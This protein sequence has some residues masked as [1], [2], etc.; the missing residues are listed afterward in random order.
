MGAPTKAQAD[1]AWVVF[2]KGVDWDRVGAD[3]LKWSPSLRKKGKKHQEML[4][5][6]LQDRQFARTFD[7]NQTI[8]KEAY[9]VAWRQKMMMSSDNGL[10]FQV[11]ERVCKEHGLT[12]P[13]LRQLQNVTTPTQTQQEYKSVLK[14]LRQN[15][16]TSARMLGRHTN[17]YSEHVK[18]LLRVGND[19]GWRSTYIHPRLGVCLLKPLEGDY[20]ELLWEEAVS[21]YCETYE[22][23][24]MTPLL[25]YMNIPTGGRARARVR[26]VLR[27]LLSATHVQQGDKWVLKVRKKKVHIHEAQ[28]VAL[29]SEG[30]TWTKHQVAKRLDV[31]TNTAKR[32]LN[33]LVEENRIMA[34]EAGKGF[35]YMAL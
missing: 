19:R 9:R 18:D 7:S 14:Y 13:E 21:T 20:Q 3:F 23:V 28:I 17:L 35:I 25:Q 32:K 24:R 26:G 12:G 34:I 6:V 2:V 15:G 11:I 1:R 27:E 29:L 33:R 4:L 16:P 8:L 30:G 5:R 31:S 22:V 10:T